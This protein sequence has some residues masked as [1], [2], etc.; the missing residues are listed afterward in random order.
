MLVKQAHIVVVVDRII[1]VTTCSLPPGMTSTL[2]GLAV[3][4]HL[5][6]VRPVQDR[7]WD[8]LTLKMITS[9]QEG[10]GQQ[11]HQMPS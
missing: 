7:G 2:P 8:K 11:D 1:M 10:G 3:R 4:F 6:R 5:S 9:C